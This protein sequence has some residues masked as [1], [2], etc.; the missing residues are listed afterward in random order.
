MPRQPARRRTPPPEP[1]DPTPAPAPAPPAPIRER[2]GREALRDRLQ[3]KYHGPTRP[4]T[5]RDW[6]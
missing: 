5:T 1:A 6:T 3:R 2:E 4:A